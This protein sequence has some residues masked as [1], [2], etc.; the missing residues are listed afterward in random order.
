M[1]HAVDPEHN[2][3]QDSAVLYIAA[4]P[5]TPANVRYMKQQAADFR[6][7]VPPED[8]RGQG[9]DETKFKGYQGEAGI[10]NDDAAR[11]AAGL[12]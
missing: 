5:T 2:G 8:F 3:T 6:A 9:T 10:P 1:I 4:V 11:R 12:H 7:G